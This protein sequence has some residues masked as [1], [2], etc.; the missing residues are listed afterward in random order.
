MDRLR[1]PLFSESTGTCRLQDLGMITETSAGEFLR[2][3]GSRL[4]SAAAL[5]Q[6]R[7][8][9]L[10]SW[11]L[12]LH[13]VLYA[14]IAAAVCI[15]VSL[16]AG[17]PELIEI[18]HVSEAVAYFASFV[19]TALAIHMYIAVERWWQLRSQMLGGLWCA[20]ND[21]A[22]ILAAQFPARAHRRLRTLVIRYCLLS[23]EIMFMQARTGQVD[24]G[25]L[26]RR[27]LLREDEREKL[28]TSAAKA[29]VVWVW[30]TGIFQRL[31]ETEKL[32]PQLA[33]KLYDICET[34]RTSL[35]GFF[36]HLETQLPFS[37][38]HLMAVLVH[39]NCLVVAGKCGLVAAMALG[40]LR[41]QNEQK[42][43]SG[44]ENLQVLLLQI[45]SAI[46]IPLFTLG[47]L[48]V[49]VLV[50]DPF[51]AQFQ[52]FPVSAFHVWMRDECEALQTAAEEV[53]SE[54]ARV[55]NQDGGSAV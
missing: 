1:R 12:W 54:I 8:T 40:N 26:S 28:E 29:Q 23:V 30:V 11:S 20:I 10:A 39:G 36:V 35:E 15:A 45:F 9:V 47:M 2:Y 3:N 14:A 31:A 50:G 7:G 5:G 13:V 25:E 18:N 38:T 17:Q 46:A 27:R 48:E 33:V 4:S 55:T 37:Y 16:C 42:P 6:I 43:A 22:M 19:A 44:S 34:G 21:L 32:P 51:G 49:G 53:P 24:F 52:D 41:G